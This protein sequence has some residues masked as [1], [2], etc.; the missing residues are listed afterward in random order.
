MVSLQGWQ[1]SSFFMGNIVVF[2][3]PLTFYHESIS[4]ENLGIR[5]CV[6]QAAGSICEAHFVINAY[7]LEGGSCVGGI[8]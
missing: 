6:R 8:T 3:L 2:F 7:L 1:Q 5:H 4:K